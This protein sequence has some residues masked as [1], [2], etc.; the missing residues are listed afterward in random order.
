MVG[1]TWILMLFI[2]GMCVG[3]FFQPYYSKPT[4]EADTS[5]APAPA[6]VPAPA[7]AAQGP[8]VLPQ[9]PVQ[10]PSQPSF[11]PT[12]PQ[13]EVLPQSAGL[14][15]PMPGGPS[16]PAGVGVGKQG[17]SLDNESGVLVQ[18]AKSLFATRERMVFQVSIPQALQLFEATE[19]R[20]PKSH[21]EFMTKI[22]QANNI[23]LPTL[24]EGRAYFFDAQQGE[25]MV[26]PSG[27]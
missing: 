8:A 12:T 27:R 18:P 13:R 21:D 6:T 2:L 22:V 17:R 9:P 10:P 1:K 20:K 25:L 7:D 11:L 23:Q 14:T 15:G 24:P 3:C 16:V 26:V 5:P 19:G 4:E